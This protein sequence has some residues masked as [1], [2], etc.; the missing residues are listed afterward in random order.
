MAV[1]KRG[2]KKSTKG[3]RKPNVCGLLGI[4][5]DFFSRFILALPHQ[6]PKARMKK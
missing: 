1:S 6:K 4:W 2:A 3:S 5:G